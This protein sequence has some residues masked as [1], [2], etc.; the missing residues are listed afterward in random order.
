MLKNN[1]EHVSTKKKIRKLEDAL[2]IADKTTV[3]MPDFIF[4]A[5]VAGIQSQI[6][7]METEVRE[8]EQ[9]TGSNSHTIGKSFNS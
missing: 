5:M 3:E 8:Y 4:D 6:D 7:D 2:R 9:L 1:R